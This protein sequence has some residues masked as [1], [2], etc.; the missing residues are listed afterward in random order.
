MIPET[1]ERQIRPCELCTFYEEEEDIC[2]LFEEGS[3]GEK[4]ERWV[5]EEQDIPC[6]YHFTVDEIMELIEST[7]DP[8]PRKD[9]IIWRAE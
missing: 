8:A 9:K 2:L 5:H 7:P 3:M 1:N 4:L 6:R